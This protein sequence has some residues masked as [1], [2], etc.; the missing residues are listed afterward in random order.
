MQPKHGSNRLLV[1]L[2]SKWYLTER[3]LIDK[4]VLAL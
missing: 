2:S 1:A 3:R 4:N